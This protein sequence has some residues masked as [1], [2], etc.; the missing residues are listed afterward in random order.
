MSSSVQITTKNGRLIA[1]I[2]LAFFI[3]ANFIWLFLPFLMAGLWSLVD[4][5]KPWSYPDIF[6][7]SLSF[8]R[9]KIVW[10][11]TSL[12]EAMFNS[13]TIAPTVSLITILL[14]LPTAY[15]FGRMDFRGKKLAELLTLIP[16]VIIIHSSALLLGMSCS[17]YLTL[18]GFYP[19]VFL[20]FRKT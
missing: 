16:L 7:Q 8:E 19:R 2:S 9:W 1:R 10:E 20:L 6:P 11:T 3:F 17:L 13:Y 12:P 14:S 15:A 5:A 4:P 18:F